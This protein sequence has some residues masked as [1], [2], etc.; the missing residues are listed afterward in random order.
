MQIELD[1]VL[2]IIEQR[3]ISIL[4]DSDDPTWTEHFSD[5]KDLIKNNAK[6]AVVSAEYT[7]L[8]DEVRT[9]LEEAMGFLKPTDRNGIN[10]SD[11]D[12]LR[13][14][15]LAYNRLSAILAKLT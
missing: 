4:E 1:L 13:R 8:R 6:P 12:R 10:W 15:A 9:E 7:K 11:G 14:A 2:K 5:L 3:R